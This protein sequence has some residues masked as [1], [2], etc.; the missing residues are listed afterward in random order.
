MPKYKWQHGVD[1]FIITAPT[2]THPLLSLYPHTP[3]ASPSLS[4]SLSVSPFLSPW[5]SLEP[6]SSCGEGAVCSLSVDHQSH[7][8]R[9]GLRK[10]I[11][12]WHLGCTHAHRLFV[13]LSF[14]GLDWF[15]NIK[16]AYCK[17]L[18]PSTGTP[19]AMFICDAQH[20]NAGS[21]KMMMWYSNQ[22]TWRLD[23]G[24]VYIV[25]SK[26]IC[27]FILSLTKVIESNWGGM[28]HFV[29]LLRFLFLSALLLCVR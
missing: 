12:R 7:L 3:P 14:C 16:N 11:F 1:S 13:P 18:V 25:Q 21:I 2:Y 17:Y 29:F 20:V 23:D 15:Y 9:W 22:H 24:W 6:L 4:L 27:I 19:H 26:L 5:K 28:T 10:H 8:H